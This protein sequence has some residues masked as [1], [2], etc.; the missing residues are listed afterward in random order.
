MTEGLYAF[1][2]LFGNRL[3][4]SIETG[5]VRSK[6]NLFFFFLLLSKALTDIAMVG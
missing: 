1:E 2:V 3:I 5:K 4:I 6:R